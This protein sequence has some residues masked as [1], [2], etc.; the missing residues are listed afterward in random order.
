VVAVAERIDVVVDFTGREGRNIVLQ[1]R[2]EQ[3]DGRGSTGDVLPPNEAMENIKFMVDLP[4]NGCELNL[5]LTSVDLVAKRRIDGKSDSTT[6]IESINI[7][8]KS[9]E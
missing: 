6:F 9:G 1:N 8:Q 2:L 3:Q 7:K 4:L 5:Q